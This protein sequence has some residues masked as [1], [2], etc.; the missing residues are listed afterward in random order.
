MERWFRKV[1]SKLR[2]KTGKADIRFYIKHNALHDKGANV[3]AAFR[4]IQ[5][6]KIVAGM[7]FLKIIWPEIDPLWVGLAGCIY[8]PG[9]TFFNW[10]VGLYWEVADGYDEEVAWNRERMAP[11]RVYVMDPEKEH[12]SFSKPGENHGDS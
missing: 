5:F 4:L 8:Y 2:K 6:E 7:A 1:C 10:L 9:R 11:T 3:V 12:N